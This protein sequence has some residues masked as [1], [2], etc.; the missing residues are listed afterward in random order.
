MVAKEKIGQTTYKRLKSSTLIEEFTSHH[1]SQPLFFIP[2]KNECG[3]T[4][5]YSL[6]IALRELGRNSKDRDLKELER[7]PVLILLLGEM[8]FLRF[9]GIV[10]FPISTT[11]FAVQTESEIWNS[12]RI[13]EGPFFETF[14]K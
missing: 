4:R 2:F 1:A 5:L 12:R 7:N 10:T 11:I 8:T 13:N 6:T 3:F 14:Q 9:I